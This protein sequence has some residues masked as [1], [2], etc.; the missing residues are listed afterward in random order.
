ME[1]S[2]Q[3]RERLSG[4]IVKSNALKIAAELGVEN[5][6][7]SNGWLDSFFRRHRITISKFNKGIQSDS[8]GLEEKSDLQIQTM[9]VNESLEEQRTL[10]EADET[11]VQMEEI[12]YDQLQED[13]KTA[14]GEYHIELIEDEHSEEA[15]ENALDEPWKSWCRMCGNCETTSVVDTERAEIVQQLL[16]VSLVNLQIVWDKL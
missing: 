7:A 16:Y 3:D 1:E 9:S 14:E 12:V 8:A 2:R 5:F 4:S 15:N 13:F 10:Q 6:S 11:E